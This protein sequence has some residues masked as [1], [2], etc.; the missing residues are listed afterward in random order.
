MEVRRGLVNEASGVQEGGCVS[1]CP[2]Q[3]KAGGKYT[4]EFTPHS[5]E[6]QNIL[7]T[8]SRQ[9]GWESCLCP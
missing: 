9:W 2:C 6:D 7:K 5:W 8:S 3:D 4:V 1:S